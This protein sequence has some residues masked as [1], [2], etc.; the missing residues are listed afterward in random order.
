[1]A[2]VHS[3]L[4]EAE[5][6]AKAQAEV[7]KRFKTKIANVTSPTKRSSF[8][9]ARQLAEDAA[10]VVARIMAP[11]RPRP[12][13]FV[14]TSSSTPPPAPIKNSAKAEAKAK[15]Q[16]KTPSIPDKPTPIQT[17]APNPALIITSGVSRAIN[18]TDEF[19][20]SLATTNWRAQQKQ[21]GL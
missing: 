10:D 13:A 12:D 15:V 5:A 8:A 21:R 1:M 2:K 9:N 6:I 16:A 7:A 19:P 14:P 20:C 11:S 18:I 4:N 17:T 3:C